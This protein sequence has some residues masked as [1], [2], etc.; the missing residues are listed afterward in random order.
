MIAA[1]DIALPSIPV[2]DSHMTYR[3]TGAAEPVA[4]CIAPDLIGFG[5]S[6]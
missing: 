2:L 3:E 5:Q 1:S 6:G 4:H